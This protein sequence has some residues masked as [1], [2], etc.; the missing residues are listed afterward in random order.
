MKRAII[1]DIITKVKTYHHHQNYTLCDRA[2]RPEKIRDAIIA[3]NNQST[4]TIHIKMI[5]HDTDHD[6]ENRRHG[7][8]ALNTYN[9]LNALSDVINEVKRPIN[10]TFACSIYDVPSEVNMS[11]M[12]NIVD[13]ENV[14]KLLLLGYEGTIDHPKVG[15]WPIA[16]DWNSRHLIDKMFTLC[17]LSQSNKKLKIYC[18]SH[19]SER[20]ITYGN[21]RQQLYDALCSTNNDNSHITFL[22]KRTGLIDVFT[23]YSNHVFVVSPHGFGLDCY[24]TWEAMLCGAIVIVKTSGLDAIYDGLPVVIVDDWSECMVKSNLLKWYELHKHKTKPTYIWPRVTYN[25]FL[26]RD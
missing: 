22:R 6:R 25:H 7:D 21:D 15:H 19:L 20:Y 18:D 12:E 4:D 9:Y 23:N 8:Y 11:G 5:V 10:I 2:V 1:K 24:R 13:H 16:V 17:T 3:V 14:K 26:N